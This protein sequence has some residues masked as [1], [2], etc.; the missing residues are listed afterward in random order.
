VTKVVAPM[1]QKFQ[2]TPSSTSDSQIPQL[3]AR[4]ADRGGAEGQGQPDGDDRAQS[5]PRDQRASEKAR[6]IH[7]DP[8]PDRRK[9]EKCLSMLGF[10]RASFPVNGPGS[11]GE[12]AILKGRK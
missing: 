3:H 9:H 11:I 2:P 7:A 4:I 10:W 1:K 12:A 6:R 8:V 5:E